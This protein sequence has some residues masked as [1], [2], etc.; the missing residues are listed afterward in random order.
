VNCIFCKADLEKG[1]VNHIVDLAEGIIIKNVPANI[2][3]QCG[4]YYIDTQIALKLEAIVE[5]VRKNNTLHLTRKH[6]LNLLS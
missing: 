6:Q 2:C 4:E 3:Q 1:S 5:E